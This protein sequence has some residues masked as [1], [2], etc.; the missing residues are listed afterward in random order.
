VFGMSLGEIM[1]I[2][3][4]AILFIG[5]DKL[6]EAMVKV[7]KFFRSFKRTINET[8]ETIEQ[9]IHLNELK[10]EA[11]SY[12]KDLDSVVNEYKFDEDLNIMDDIS[13]SI[14]DVESS[15]KEIATKSEKPKK[16][17]AKN[18]K[19]KKE[20]NKDSSDV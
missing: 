5:P 4:I 6:P 8:K 1:I 15:V 9:E 14:K 20:I 16:K 2:A 13:S 17:K 7:A 10:E 3:I 12:K 18:K 11:L 19:K